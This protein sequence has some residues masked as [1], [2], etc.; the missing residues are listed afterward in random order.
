MLVQSQD[1][2]RFKQFEMQQGMSIGFDEQP[3]MASN[4]EILAP[5]EQDELNPIVY[6]A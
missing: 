1:D 3:L 2:N 5:F 4:L 6:Q